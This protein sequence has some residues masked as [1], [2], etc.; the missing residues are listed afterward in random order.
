MILVDV[1]SKG[2]GSDPGIEDFS[3][4]DAGKVKTDGK[5]GSKGGS[6]SGAVS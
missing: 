5:S 3:G 6:G 2:A 1:V 4:L